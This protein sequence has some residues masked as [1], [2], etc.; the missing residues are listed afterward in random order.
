MNESIKFEGRLALKKQ[1]VAQLRIRL[2]GHRD[3][4]RDLLDPFEDV[5]DLKTDQI[6]DQAVQ[7]AGFQSDYHAALAEIA[8]INKALGRPA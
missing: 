6:A 2:E 1:E 8:A 4:L 3:S 5:G 7:L